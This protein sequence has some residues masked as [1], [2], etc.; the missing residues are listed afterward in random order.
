MPKIVDRE[1]MQ[2]G[3]LHAA[4]RVY[5]EKGYHS[6]TIADVAH[7]A[8]VAKG[9]IYLYYKNKEALALS[10]MHTHFDGMQGRFFGG[11]KPATLDAFAKSLTK[12]MTVPDDDARYIRLFFEVFGEKF[13]SDTFMEEFGGFFDRLGGHYADHITHLQAIGE[14]RQDADPRNLGRLLAAMVDGIILHRGFFSI[15]ERKHAKLRIELAAM[16]VRGLAA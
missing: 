13:T 3:I 16:F 12:T 14:I 9:T 11:K 15:P 10:M 7:A 4:Q 8:G 6:A 5:L 2:L 1:E